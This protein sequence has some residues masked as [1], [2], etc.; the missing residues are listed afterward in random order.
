MLYIFLKLIPD[1]TLRFKGE[2]CS[3][4]KLSKEKITVL[5]VANMTGTVKKKLLITRKS[6]SL[7]CFKGVSSLPVFYENNIKAW[8][9]SVIFE[10][11]LKFKR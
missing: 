1:K 9:T 2:I 10:K 4:E 6:K 11:N 3:G 7:R 8:I 5:V